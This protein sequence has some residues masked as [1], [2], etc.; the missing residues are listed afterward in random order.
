MSF[1]IQKA[2]NSLSESQWKL[3][4]DSLQCCGYLQQNRT[5]TICTE[6]TSDCESFLYG[7]LNMLYI[8][9]AFIIVLFVLLVIVDSSSCSWMH[10]LR[11][12]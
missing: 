4:Q 10:A 6:S 8:V 2:I 12:L 9:A 1:P 7:H 11:L 3:V 5:A